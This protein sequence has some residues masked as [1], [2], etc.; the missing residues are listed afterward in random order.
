MPLDDRTIEL[1]NSVIDGEASADERA[2]LEAI[3][4]DSAEAR[5]LFE[6]TQELAGRFDGAVRVDP[7]SS[8]RSEIMKHV[9]GRTDSPRSAGVVV[10]H[11]AWSKRKVWFG[12]GWAAVA[13]IVLAVIVLA[14]LR[15]IGRRS[16]DNVRAT[17]APQTGYDWP[18]IATMRSAS[19]DAQLIIRRDEELTSLECNI[20]TS[21]PASVSLTW[22]ESA[23]TAVAISAG[24]DASS[25]K[26]QFN[27]TVQPGAGRTSVIVRRR[28]GARAVEV[29]V[30][31]DSKQVIRAVVPLG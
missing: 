11:P 29:V 17:M 2:H 3:L 15:L 23:A 28:P 5:Q 10:G 14:P 30:S 7:P 20:R 6:A 12:L 21:K 4:K 13:A 22:D 19:G 25:S 18:V 31:V 27:F 16:G 8:M 1:I 26:G 9:A 24:R